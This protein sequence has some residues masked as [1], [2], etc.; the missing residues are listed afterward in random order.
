MRVFSEWRSYQGGGTHAISPP[1]PCQIR[2]EIACHRKKVGRLRRGAPPVGEET[3]GLGKGGGV[4]VMV[5]VFSLGAADSLGFAN[6]PSKWKQT[7]KTSG[8]G[9]GQDLASPSPEGL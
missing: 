5:V 7:K 1:I 8:L 3:A 4:V 2:R 6:S 9:Y